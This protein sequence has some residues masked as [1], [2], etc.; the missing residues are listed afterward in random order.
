MHQKFQVALV[1]EFQDTDNVQYEIFSALFSSKRH[2]LFMIGDPKQAIY[3]FRGADIF[4]YMKASRNAASK[5]T[6]IENWRSDP[7]LIT[8]VNTIFSNVKYR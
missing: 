4:S 5:F 2:L 3:G 7:G 8:A 1:D 6:L